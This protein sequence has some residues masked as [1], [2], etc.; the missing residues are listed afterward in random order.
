ME[1]NEAIQTITKELELT[2]VS[3]PDIVNQLD[4]NASLR[5]FCLEVAGGVG[6]LA[7][8]CLGLERQSTEQRLRLV[9]LGM[10]SLLFGRSLDR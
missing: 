9:N 3:V 6:R 4:D 2:D 10:Q 1:V 8:R 5:Q 7:E